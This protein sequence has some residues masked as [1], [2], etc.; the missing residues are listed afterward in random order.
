MAGV[1]LAYK[2]SDYELAAYRVSNYFIKLGY[3]T[4][5][6][7]DE[8]GNYNVF[9]FQERILKNIIGTPSVVKVTFYSF[10]DSTG[11]E[12]KNTFVKVNAQNVIKEVLSSVLILPGVFKLG[13]LN[14]IKKLAKKRVLIEAEKLKVCEK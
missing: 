9:I 4:D 10:E 6:K 11:I 14:K 7:K 1:N 13:Q 3:S 2:L 12:V 8:N 5:V